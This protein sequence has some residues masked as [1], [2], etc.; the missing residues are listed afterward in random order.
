MWEMISS[1]SANKLALAAEPN[2]GRGRR[3]VDFILTSFSAIRDSAT[4]LSLRQLSRRFER[5]AFR[6]RA[7]GYWL[8]RFLPFL[9]CA[10]LAPKEQRVQRQ[11]ATGRI[12]R[13][14]PGAVPQNAE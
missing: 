13:G 8:R 3:A 14:E 9:F 12:R 7:S 4:R 11:S 6:E 1:A 10:G 5:C 2:F